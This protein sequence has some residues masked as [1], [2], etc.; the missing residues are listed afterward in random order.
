MVNGKDIETFRIDHKKIVESIMRLNIVESLDHMLQTAVRTQLDTM[1]HN[2]K[3]TVCAARKKSIVK[4]IQSPMVSSLGRKQPAEDKNGDDSIAALWYCPLCKE[5]VDDGVACDLCESWY[6][7]TCENLKEADIMII[8]AQR[9]Y[10]CSSCKHENGEELKVDFL[11]QDSARNDESSDGTNVDCEPIQAPPPPPPPNRSPANL[12][13]L[14]FIHPLY[15]KVSKEILRSRQ[16]LYS[17]R[18]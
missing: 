9:E 12:L 15:Q 11:I 14:T 4:A 17:L 6:H 5:K 1:T 10:Y 3:S 18:R 13:H 2:P 16:A 8:E 7:Y